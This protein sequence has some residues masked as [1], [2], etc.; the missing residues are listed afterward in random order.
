MSHPTSVRATLLAVCA[1][2]ILAFPGAA[3]AAS[4]ADRDVTVMTRNLYLGADLIPLA[5]SPDLA[6]FEQAAAQRFQT[7]LA[8]DFRVRARAL[9]REIARAR[10]DLVGLQEAAVW[11]RSPDGVKD[12]NATPATQT[13]YD[14]LAVLQAEL[15]RQGARYRVVAR[16]AWFD[17]EA[18]TALGHDV[19]LTQYD[20]ILART[21]RGARVRTGR[22]FRG[23]FTRTFDVPTQAG[24][25]R[26]TRGW[27]GVDARLGRR[28]FRFVT[29]HLEAYSAEIAEAQMRQLLSGPLASR[30]RQTILVGDFNSDPRTAA[31]DRGTN[32]QPSA[33]ATAIARGFANPLP[34]R[35]TCCFGEDLRQT[36]ERLDSWIDHVIVRPRVRRIRS[37]IVGA[38]ASERVGG[39][40]PSDHAGVVATL[41]LR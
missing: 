25:A 38:R 28:S 35:A 29:T 14:A 10:P 30:R 33:Y 41:R 37:S 40:W 3:P 26:S 5:T 19:R 24:L 9:A 21:G 23:G 17:F 6:A 8:N 22:T 2:L 27:V 34:R 32:R 39:L 1:L 16:R 13:V 7:V 4:A 11:R 31:G 36:S 20:A 12:G 15:R 18:P